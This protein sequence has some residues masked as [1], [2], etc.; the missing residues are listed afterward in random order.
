M[1]MS[2]T[3][4]VVEGGSLPQCDLHSYLTATGSCLLLSSMGPLEQI[5][6]ESHPCPEILQERKPWEVQ[7]PFEY[8]VTCSVP[9]AGINAMHGQGKSWLPNSKHKS[10]IWML[11][12]VVLSHVTTVLS[13]R[14]LCSDALLASECAFTPVSSLHCTSQTLI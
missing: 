14:G 4:L 6:S 7:L 5:G 12:L 10:P 3:A 13:D 9:N 2:D 1:A 8:N 11:F